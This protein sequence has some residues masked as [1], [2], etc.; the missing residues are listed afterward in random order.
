M[1]NVF[2]A[3]CHFNY[4]KSARPY[5]QMM[6]KLPSSHPWLYNN[7]FSNGYHTV[8]RGDRYWAGLWTDLTIEQVMMRTI[9]SCGGLT[10]GRG[11][12][13]SVRMLW[14]CIQHA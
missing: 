1:L 7:L 11:V 2:A 6:L 9:K 4:A 10:R 13:E 14:I 5:Q 8:Q 12:S 3:T